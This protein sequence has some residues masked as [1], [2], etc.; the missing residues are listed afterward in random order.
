MYNGKN[1]TMTCLAAQTGS[2]GIAVL[3]NFGTR[4]EWVVTATPW[5]WKEPHYPF[6]KRLGGPLGWYGRVEE[7]KSCCPHLGLSPKLFI[8]QQVSIPSLLSQTSF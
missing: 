7:E 1:V 2:R 5:P 4:W 8:L 6:Y 3:L